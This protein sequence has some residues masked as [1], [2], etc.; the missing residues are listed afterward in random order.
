MS[1]EKATIPARERSPLAEMFVIAAPT[2]ATMAT[3]TVMQFADGLMVS[4][5]KPASPVYVTAQ[6]NGGMWTWIAISFVLGLVGVIN[7]Y[8]AQHLGKGEPR[9]GS[10]YGWVGVWLSLFFWVLLIPY[11]MVLPYVFRKL[12][13][14]G[15]TLSLETQYAQICLFGAI[16]TMIGR[17]VGQ[18]FFGLH[19]AKVPLIA[20]SV[21]VC[22][23]VAANWVLIYGN[24]GAPALGLA[25][26]AYGTVIGSFTEM[27]V[28]VM[29]FL[30]PRYAKEYGTRAVWK[31]KFAPIVDVIKLGWPGALMMVNEM[32]CWGYL[33][34]GLLP[35][36]GRAA[37]QSGDLHNAVGWIALRYMHIA[38]MPAA[39]MSIALTAIVGRCMGMKRPDLAVKRA[40][41]GMY[42]TIGYMGTCGLFMV[43]FREQAVKVFIDPETSPEMI[44][45]M[46]A[47]GSWV[48]ILA[49]IFQVFD[50][51]GM[52]MTGV[53]RGA[54]DTVWPG[55]VSIVFCW[56]TLIGGG[57]LMIHFW[58]QMGSIGPWIAA[59]G[60][61]ILLGL[62]LFVRFLGGKWKTMEVIREV[63]VPSLTQTGPEE[64][65]TAPPDAISGVSPGTP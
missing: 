28:L 22:V 32:L 61:I 30:S 56:V 6:G 48:L 29:V 14:E 65:L 17:G 45:Q 2:I 18:F 35:A 54:G 24:L 42:L 8:V 27:L 10:A 25:G 7:T 62:A 31:P 53:L 13:H 52:A 38:F 9:K 20:A 46:V 4:R 59:S 60:Y 26:A 64:D 11:A 23:N 19:R 63:G 5:I 47:L 58:P 49:C 15:Q 3:Y 50:A 55:V 40:W 12:G 37:G 33:M 16:F 36:A 57:H 43:I 51:L 34:T 41:L 1:T 21:A 44:E 39:G